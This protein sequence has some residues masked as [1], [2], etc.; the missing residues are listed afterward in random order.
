MI[1]NRPPKLQPAQLAVLQALSDLTGELG[2]C[3]TLT[4]MAKRI[5]GFLGSGERCVAT[6]L[7]ELKTMGC[8]ERVGKG[9]WRLTEGFTPS[10]VVRGPY[11]PL[12]QAARAALALLPAG[13]DFDRLGVALRPFVLAGERA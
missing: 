5:G 13:A 12:V 11:V 1:A 9:C 3:P 7:T 2:R 6:R 10:L 8:V 4:E